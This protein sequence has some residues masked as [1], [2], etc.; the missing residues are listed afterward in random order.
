MG[1]QRGG[2]MIRCQSGCGN[3]FLPINKRGPSPKFCSNACKQKHYR[4]TT[5]AAAAQDKKPVTFLRRSATKVMGL[6][7]QESWDCDGEDCCKWFPPG[8][9]WECYRLDDKKFCRQC[10]E[11][12]Q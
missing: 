5:L 9:G 1:E 7:N 12:K 2:P 4:Q 6:S 11:V 3:D 10:F 8:S